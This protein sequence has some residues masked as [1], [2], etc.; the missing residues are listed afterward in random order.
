MPAAVPGR[1][2]SELA[3]PNPLGTAASTPTAKRPDRPPGPHDA[4]ASPARVFAP[5][6]LHGK[7]TQAPSRRSPRSRPRT[8][9]PPRAPHRRPHRRRRRPWRHRRRR[10]RRRRQPQA[11][12]RPPRG[13]THCSPTSPSGASTE[14]GAELRAVSV[15]GF[16]IGARLVERACA[17]QEASL[18]R[19]T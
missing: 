18:S 8:S 7:T 1:R 2:Q 3:H 16:R 6:R 12:L 11:A 10:R 19:V 9:P 15:D 14:R 13:A 4:R 17:C 5:N